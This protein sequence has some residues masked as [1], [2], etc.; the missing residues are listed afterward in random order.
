M[1]QKRQRGELKDSI[2]L[3]TPGHQLKH[4]RSQLLVIEIEDDELVDEG[5][6]VIKEN[7]VVTMTSNQGDRP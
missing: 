7:G 2:I 3:F 4:K 1:Q 5:I 6:E